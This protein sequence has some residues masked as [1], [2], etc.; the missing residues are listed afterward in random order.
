MG[1]RIQE[2]LMED[3]WEDTE[4]LVELMNK[5][6][7]ERLAIF[8]RDDIKFPLYSDAA[9]WTDY[10]DDPDRKRTPRKFCVAAIKSKVSYGYVGKATPK[11]RKEIEQEGEGEEVRV[12]Y[13]VYANNRYEQWLSYRESDRCLL[14]VL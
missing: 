3:I 8:C 2:V 11:I 7:G 5:H 1:V 6:E 10:S 13:E 14:V 9:H 4:K 12:L